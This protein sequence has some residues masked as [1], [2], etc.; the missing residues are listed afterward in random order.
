MSSPI[1]NL[2]LERR[3]PLP[4]FRASDRWAPRGTKNAETRLTAYQIKEYLARYPN[5]LE[6][7]LLETV[8]TD[9][10]NDILA[11]KRSAP[12]CA[13]PFLKQKH[14]IVKFNTLYSETGI[15]HLSRRIL[16][17]SKD[18]DICAQIYDIC[19]VVGSSVAAHDFHLYA[20]SANGTE[21]SLY[22]P[23]DKLKIVGPIG[24][25]LTVS[26]HVA[27]KKHSLNVTDLPQDS[28]FPKGMNP[29]SVND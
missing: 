8:S 26:A 25:H 27:H 13:V 15:E 9:Y 5:V 18:E 14:S 21:L 12:S 6:E 24:L 22:K 19:Q 29:I 28:R 10:L 4:N 1:R 3:S 23:G 16:T 7:F 20:A 11:K 2:R 17:C